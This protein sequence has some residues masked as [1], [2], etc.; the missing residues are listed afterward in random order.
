MNASASPFARAQ[1]NE[2][3]SYF[4]RRVTFSLHESFAEP[5]RVC[6]A[7]PFEVTEQGWGEFVIG[8]TVQFR[9]GTLRQMDLQHNLRLFPDAQQ[10]RDLPIE[11]RRPVVAERFDEFVFVDPRYGGRTD[12]TERMRAFEIFLDSC[13]RAVF[14]ILKVCKCSLY[15]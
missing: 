11:R 1:D 3:L 5:V 10:Q 15:F 8:L 12:A 9:D 7:P 2:D 13:A 6:D 14:W 4:I